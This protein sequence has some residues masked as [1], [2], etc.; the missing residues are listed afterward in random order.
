MGPR[1]LRA[2]GLPRPVRVIAG[3]GGVPHAI[4]VDG[5]RRLVT[6]VIED[7]LVQDRW[8]TEEPVDRH[9]FAL[10]IEPGRR[11][12]VFRDERGGGWFS[13]EAI[14]RR[15]AAGR[16]PR[17]TAGGPTG[18]APGAAVRPG[19]GHPRS[20]PRP[21]PGRPRADGRDRPGAAAG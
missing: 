1:S 5:R 11:V 20:A 8:W 21:G 18:S 15:R 17:V 2:L 9:Y 4:L 6:E 14:E 3:P 10:V 19:D 16:T 12:E 13:H 7:W